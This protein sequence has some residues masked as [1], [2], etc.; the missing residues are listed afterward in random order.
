MIFTSR[1]SS[2][3]RC[4]CLDMG[5]HSRK[6]GPAY[7]PLVLQ[8]RKLILLDVQHPQGSPDP[9][10]LE[11]RLGRR[12]ACVL[13]QSI[14][15]HMTKVLVLYYSSWGHIEQMAYAAAE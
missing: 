15:V 13:I 5:L 7:L 9:T 12:L 2:H 8:G 14:G 11:E 6:R 3:S 1:K 4:C 10:S